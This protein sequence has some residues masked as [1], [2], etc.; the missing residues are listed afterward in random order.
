MPVEPT[1]AAA[2]TAAPPTAA[3][4]GANGVGEDLAEP[5]LADSAVVPSPRFTPEFER[6]EFGSD[7]GKRAPATNG[8]AKHAQIAPELEPLSA[9]AGPWYQKPRTDPISI[10]VDSELCVRVH[11]YTV[12]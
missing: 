10:E 4:L 9:P 2:E 11:A 7:L 1:Y 8:A 5:Q 6:G 12:S 3:E